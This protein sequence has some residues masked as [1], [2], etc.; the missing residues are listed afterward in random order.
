MARS[1]PETPSHKTGKRAAS[2]RR[3]TG[4]DSPAMSS[5]HAEGDGQRQLVDEMKA[6]IAR[7]AFELFEQLKRLSGDPGFHLDRKSTRLNSSHV[8]I[9]YAVFCLKKKKKPK[10]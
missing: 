6:R 10:P 7:K 2:Q 1:T 5:A 9:S 3:G 4:S 8:R